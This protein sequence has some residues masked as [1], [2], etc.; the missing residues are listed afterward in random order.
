MMD[1]VLI[2]DLSGSVEAEYNLIMDFSRALTLGLS[3][4]TG[5]ARVGVVA[6]SDNVSDVIPLN[7]F[8]RQQRGL[9][10]RFNFP[11]HRGETNIQVT[12]FA[13]S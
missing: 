4:N 6:F 2:L 11:H 7:E 13:L 12:R 3:I 10:E 9:I 8:I 1:V 5:A